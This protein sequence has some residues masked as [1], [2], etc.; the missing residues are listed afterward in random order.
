[1]NPDGTDQKHIYTDLYGGQP[2]WSPDGTKIVFITS[3]Y[4]AFSS[5]IFT[6]NPDGTNLTPLYKGFDYPKIVTD[7][8]WSP[9][10]NKL[11]V[12]VM[13]GWV[14]EISIINLK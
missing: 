14:R 9:D 7:L 2:A 12:T 13:S 5:E 11:A 4:D 3:A 10:G 1:M 8:S 6:I